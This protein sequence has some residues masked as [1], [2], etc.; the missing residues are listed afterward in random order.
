MLKLL[1]IL[2]LC[3]AIA[4]LG[5]WATVNINTADAAA[6]ERVKGIGPAKARAILEYRRQHGPFLS[7]DDLV[8]VPGIGE[9]TLS[10]LRDQVSVTE[11]T[12]LPATNS[13]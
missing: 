1:R 11:R 5:A 8:R 10:K 13:K 12:R 3:I 7:V 2:A 6:L 4:P 9:K